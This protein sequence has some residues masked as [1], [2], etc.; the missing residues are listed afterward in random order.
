MKKSSFL[1]LALPVILGALLAGTAQS[2]PAALWD[3]ACGTSSNHTVDSDPVGGV[4]GT[5]SDH[6]KFFAETEAEDDLKAK[7]GVES[8]VVCAI[9]NGTGLQCER[10]VELGEGEMRVIYIWDE[11]TETWTCKKFWLPGSEYTVNCASC[12]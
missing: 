3:Q 10:S 9:C 2:N 4:Q 11:T 8:G 12:S 6:V 7:L 5:G 1:G